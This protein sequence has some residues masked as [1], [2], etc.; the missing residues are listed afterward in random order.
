MFLGRVRL[1][2]PDSSLSAEENLTHAPA[3]TAEP[4]AGISGACCAV[5]DGMGPQIT[6]LQ[7]YATENKIT[8]IYDAANE[9]L[10]RQQGAKGGFPVTRISEIASVLSPGLA[11]K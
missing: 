6:W 4:Q 7:S 1:G 10:I 8:C 3:L 11:G 9:D 2:E 5:L